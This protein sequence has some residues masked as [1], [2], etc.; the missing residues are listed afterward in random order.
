MMGAMRSGDG[1]LRQEVD[2]AGVTGYTLYADGQETAELEMQEFLFG[3]VRYLKPKLIF[4]SGS[5][6]G[7]TARILGLACRAN[8]RGR[9]VS[10]EAEQSLFNTARAN[11]R[12]VPEVEVR[13][14]KA[15]DCLE[16]EEADLVFSDSSYESRVEEW[17]ACKRGCVY[18][19]HDTELEKPLGIFV[20]ARNG[21]LIKRGR[22]FGMMVK[23]DSYEPVGR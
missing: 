17:K 3:L 12:G 11:C 7:H 18:V 15:M 20:Q 21:L 16:V 19:V 2:L 5:C 4:E 1:S 9:V 23:G 6:R 10:A 8:G 22:G 14:A 13:H